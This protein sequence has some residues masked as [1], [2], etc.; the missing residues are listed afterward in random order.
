M[1]CGVA[2]RGVPPVL[3]IEAEDEASLAVV[4]SGRRQPVHRHLGTAGGD[5]EG[6]WRRGGEVEEEEEVVREEGRAHQR[7]RGQ[8]LRLPRRCGRRRR[9][10]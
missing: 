2:F 1:A 10:S 7:A 4:M 6:R 9:L 3:A 5:V 8:H